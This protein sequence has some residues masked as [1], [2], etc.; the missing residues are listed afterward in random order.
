MTALTQ[1]GIYASYREKVLSYLS[2]KT[3]SPEDAEDLCETVFE[4]VCRSL[5]RFEG[6]ASLSTWIYRITRYTLIDY[7][8][9]KRPIEPLTEELAAPDDLEED[10][11]HRETLERLAFALK[12]LP[13]EERDIIVLR[14]YR[15]KTLTEI[16]RLTGIS[17]GM[18]KVKH[19][20]ALEHLRRKMEQEIKCENEKRGSWPG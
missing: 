16:S 5:P 3:E 2:G 1:D 13:P 8:R 14:Y 6:K 12:A 17:Y 19:K 7:Y 11:I 20:T 4:Q 9:T 10:F 15:E 18:V